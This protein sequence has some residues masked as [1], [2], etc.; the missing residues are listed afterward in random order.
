MDKN[1]RIIE[2]LG[3]EGNFRGDLVP[4][5]FPGAGT[6]STRPGCS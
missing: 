1:H 2:W 3:L 5:S 6:L 4:T